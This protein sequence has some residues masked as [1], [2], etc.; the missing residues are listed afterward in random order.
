MY[1]LSV[2]KSL[3]EV[4]FKRRSDLKQIGSDAFSRS[5]PKAELNC[6]IVGS[7][8]GDVEIRNGGNTQILFCHRDE[9][10]LTVSTSNSVA[11]CPDQP[12][13]F[14]VGPTLLERMGAGIL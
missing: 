10:G 4:I 3:I 8:M 11:G 7:I 12:G 9:H 6:W 13:A 5:A 1:C 2:C 14:G